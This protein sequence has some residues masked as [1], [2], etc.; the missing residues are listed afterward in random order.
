VPTVD[1]PF[2]LAVSGEQELVHDAGK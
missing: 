2:G 1:A